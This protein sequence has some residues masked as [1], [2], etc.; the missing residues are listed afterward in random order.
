MT[1]PI[2]KEL[3]PELKNIE[4]AASKSNWKKHKHEIYT[5]QENCERLL[6]A[7]KQMTSSIRMMKTMEKAY[8]GEFQ[9]SMAEFDEMNANVLDAVSFVHYSMDTGQM[10]ESYQ[11]MS[12]AMGG[13]KRSVRAKEKSGA[14]RADDLSKV[15]RLLADYDEARTD[16]RQALEKQKTLLQEYMDSL[17]QT[18]ANEGKAVMKQSGGDPA[19]VLEQIEKK[20]YAEF[21][22]DRSGKH[23]INLSREPFIQE[24][25]AQAD[26]EVGRTPGTEIRRMRSRKGKYERRL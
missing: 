2:N 15:K 7:K 8:V 24:C 18:T 22:V 26:S 19:A 23:I 20:M 9:V 16:S 5:A 3:E 25:F 13:L 10:E 14:F 6:E 21:P 12:R 1:A 4:S 17:K 11:T